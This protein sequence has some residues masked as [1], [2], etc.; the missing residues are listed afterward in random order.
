MLHYEFSNTGVEYLWILTWFW[1][2]II[3]FIRV[4]D[5]SKIGRVSSM[6]IPIPIVWSRPWFV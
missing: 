5:T 3:P 4:W 2:D 1:A 6:S